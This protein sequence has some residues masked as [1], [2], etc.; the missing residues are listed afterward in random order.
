[1][2][3]TVRN[4]IVFL[5]HGAEEFFDGLRLT[6][7][8]LRWQLLTKQKAT[9]PTNAQRVF[10]LYHDLKS[11]L[12]TASPLLTE[13]AGMVPGTFTL[14]GSSVPSKTW[15]FSA[16]PATGK[17]RRKRRRKGRKSEKQKRFFSAKE[18]NASFDFVRINKEW[19]K[20]KGRIK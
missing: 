18:L 1:M 17:N 6:A 13:E 16:S 7:M 11:K 2:L 3:F 4:W 19:L 20:T 10:K 15:T 12:T 5:L 14:S 9:R 8:H